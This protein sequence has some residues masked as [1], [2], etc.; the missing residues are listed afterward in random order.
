MADRDDTRPDEIRQRL[1]GVAAGI[2]VGE[3]EQAR[4]GV[5][6][7]VGRRRTRKRLGALLGAAAVVA[8]AATTVVLTFGGDEPD[9][10]VTTDDTMPPDTG[11]D[12]IDDDAPEPTLALP[13]ATAQ[14][15]EL[16]DVT[17]RPGAAAGVNGA[18][19]YGEWI[20]PWEDGF[21]VGSTSFPPQ[22]LPDE[23]PD[24]VL[25]LFPQE[26]IDF[27]NGELPDTIAEATERLSAAGLLDTVSEI[28]QAN[29]AA[30]EAIY[31]APTD[32]PTL[33]VRFTVDGTTWEPREMVLPAGADYLSSVTAVGGRLTTVFGNVD[34]LT[35]RSADGAI[36]V[37]TTTDLTNWTTQQIVVPSPGELPEGINWNASAQGL[38]ANDNGWVLSVYDSIDVDAFALLPP[39]VRAEVESGDNGLGVSTD[40]RGMTIEYGFDP[41]GGNPSETLTFTWDELGVSPETALLL[42][43]NYESTLWASTWEGVPVPTDGPSL[44]GPML[45]TPDGFVLWSDQTWFSPDGITWTASPL[46]GEEAWVSGAFNVDG[47]MIVMSS[48]NT[49]GKLVH[50]VDDRG[51]NAVLLDLPIPVDGTLSVGYLPEGA[52]A[53]GRILFV[54]RPIT[55]N[56]EPDVEPG[57]EPEIQLTVEVDGYRLTLLQQTGVFEVV[58]MATG[59]VVVSEVPMQLGNE[60][61][62]IQLGEDGVTVIDPATGEVLVMFPT[63]ALDAAER[64]FLDAGGEFI[65]GGG[66]EYDP[67]LWLVASLDGQ[68][69]VV[70]D[71]ADVTNGPTSLTTNGSRLLL[72]LGADWLLFDL[73]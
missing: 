68:R 57:I 45:A 46:P 24:D 39:D 13:I 28:I 65:D 59:D 53:S 9:T 16:I 34:P 56:V 60:N 55:P 29:P 38:V 22:P 20:V 52:Y 49:G 26:V 15:V 69:F 33:D 18:P 17:S 30:Y 36:T 63:D 51:Q 25:A 4:A 8:V 67:D 5:D 7:L 27:F 71:L 44:G 31:G 1:D 43:Q 6:D 54:D 37:A 14:P 47:G 64:E 23:L 32:A 58:D 48:T 73:A 3:L 10:L 61:S 72:Q 42:D 40:G 21:L 19:E 2:D 70:E 11:P 41:E 66:G 35:G 50:R 62:S 12:E